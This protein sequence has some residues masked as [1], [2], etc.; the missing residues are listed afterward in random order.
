MILQNIKYMILSKWAY[1]YFLTMRHNVIKIS[2]SK[3]G[4]DSYLRTGVIF[5]SLPKKLIGNAHGFPA[6]CEHQMF[7][8]KWR[9]RDRHIQSTCQIEV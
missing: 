9:T 3:G 4:I 7:N 5:Y 6:I 2:N 1:I 8:T